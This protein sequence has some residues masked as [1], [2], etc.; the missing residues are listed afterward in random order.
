MEEMQ[1]HKEKRTR[2]QDAVLHMR[3][4][5]C[6]KALPI[7]DS[8]VKPDVSIPFIPPWYGRIEMEYPIDRRYGDKNTNRNSG[9][10]CKFTQK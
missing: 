5:P 7:G 9:Q 6:M 1:V 4:P 8:L 10:R 2:R 3:E